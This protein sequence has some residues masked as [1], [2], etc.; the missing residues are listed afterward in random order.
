[1]SGCRTTLHCT[2]CYFNSFLLLHVF[3]ALNVRILPSSLSALWQIT[4]ICINALDRL[5]MSK[6]QSCSYHDKGSSP[7]S[8]SRRSQRVRSQCLL[9]DCIVYGQSCHNED[10]IRHK[11]SSQSECCQNNLLKVAWN[12]KYLQKLNPVSFTFTS[13]PKLL[14]SDFLSPQKPCR[15]FFFAH[16]CLTALCSTEFIPGRWIVIKLSR[17][18]ITSSSVNKLFLKLCNSWSGTRQLFDHQSQTS[19]QAA[20][21]VLFD[22]S[23]KWY[24]SGSLEQLFYPSSLHRTPL[25]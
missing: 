4:L 7:A 22:I 19:N 23:A 18:Q 6:V 3:V 11:C 12:P 16:Y 9:A 5:C 15:I 24:T 1:M 8:Q 20:S 17:Q 21:Y 14:F 10:V 25:K 2:H 13:P